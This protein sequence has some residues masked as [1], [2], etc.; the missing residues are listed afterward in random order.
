MDPRSFDMVLTET[1]EQRS[2]LV[3]LRVNGPA[4]VLTSRR[5]LVETQPARSS[6]RRRNDRDILDIS[7]GH[8]NR[9][10]RHHLA[11]VAMAARTGAS[12]SE[13][14]FQWQVAAE[15]TES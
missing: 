7:D 13:M 15:A 10:N 5:G 2:E 12:L 3:E 14:K 8:N 1:T 9:R 11:A 4:A 6:G